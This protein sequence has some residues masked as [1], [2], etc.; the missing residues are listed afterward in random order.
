MSTE[1]NRY[2]LVDA[3]PH[4]GSNKLPLIVQ[5]IRET[6]LHYGGEINFESRVT[7]FIIS[8]NK[9]LGVVVNNSEEFFGDSVILSTGHSKGIFF[10]AEKN[11]IRTESKPFA[12]G[13]P[14]RTSSG[15][16]LMKY[17]TGRIREADFFPHLVINWYHR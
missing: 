6:I 5:N 11:N 15:S 1:L 17:N 2:I 10:F 4:I 13:N 12:M 14:H 16:L 9:I 7:D 3:H 8:E